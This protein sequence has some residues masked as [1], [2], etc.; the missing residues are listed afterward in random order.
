MPSTGRI[1]ALA[2]R[3]HGVVHLSQA[4]TCNVS[5]RSVQRLV[6]D[7]WERLHRGVYALP[8]SLPTDQRAGA[9]ALLAVGDHAALASWTAARL[10]NLTDRHR[11]PVHVLIPHASHRP[12]L[13]GVRVRSTRILAADDIVQRN[14]LRLTSPERSLCDIAS[15]CTTAQ[16]VELVAMAVQRGLCT[17][18]GLQDTAQRLGQ[19]PGSRGL[20]VA[21]RI[22]AQDGRTDS[23]LER[24]VRRELRSAGLHPAPGT[25]EL[26]LNDGRVVWLDIAFP[27]Q[28]VALEVDGFAWHATPAQ[29]QRDH[30][31]QNSIVSAGWRLL[32]VS[33]SQLSAPGTFIA[34]LREL[35]SGED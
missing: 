5:A 12:S 10:W 19:R 34:Q 9:A 16:L 3:Q 32:R 31:R 11:W 15:D 28:Q 24:R 33:N 6:A 2:Q 13:R 21:L 7:G 17:L 27:T 20:S 14:G 30:E 35:L 22:L 4:I 18:S 1:V 25:F 26:R 8:G 23:P 29:L